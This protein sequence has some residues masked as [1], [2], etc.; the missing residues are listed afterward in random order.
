MNKERKIQYL[1]TMIKIIAFLLIL[2]ICLETVYNVTKRKDSFRKMSNFFEQEEDFDVLF[3]G[4]S[5]TLY[6]IFPSELWKKY[7]IVSYNMGN[8]SETMVTTYYNILQAL[9]HTTPKV[10]VI[11]AFACMWSEKIDSGREEEIVHN[12]LDAYPVSY[13]KYLAIR[14]IFEGRNIWDKCFEYLFDFSI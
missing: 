1:K 9:K 2:F 8:P 7:G 14:D 6:G 11:D 4:S 13:T 5:H 10:V 3:F 12:S